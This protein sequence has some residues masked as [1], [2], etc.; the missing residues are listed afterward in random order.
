MRYLQYA[1]AEEFG[2]II[3]KHSKED[4]MANSQAGEYVG[5]VGAGDIS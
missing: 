5:E 2:F 4:G 3:S 1:G